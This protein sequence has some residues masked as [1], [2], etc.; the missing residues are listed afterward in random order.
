MNVLDILILIVAILFGLNGFYR[1]LIHQIFFFVSIF[2]GIAGG[3][4]A[5]PYVGELFGFISKSPDV[6]R[7]LGFAV[8]F[9]LIS[10]LVG[11]IGRLIHRGTR[12]V[13]LG[14]ADHF[15]GA[16]FGAGAALMVAAFGVFVLKALLPANS[17]FVRGSALAPYAETVAKKMMGLV[18]GSLVQRFE[19]KLRDIRTGRTTAA[20]ARPAG[21]VVLPPAG[22]AV[23]YPAP[24]APMLPPPAVRTT[25]TV[26]PSQNARGLLVDVRAANRTVRVDMRYASTENFVRQRLYSA[27]RCLLVPGVVQRLGRVQARL[28]K[29]RLGLKLWDCYRPLSVQRQLWAAA[30][31]PGYIGDPSIGSNHNRGAAVDVTLVDSSGRELAMPTD[32]DE[33]SPRAHHGAPASPAARQNREL[34]RQEMTRAG[35]LTL[36]TEWW[37]YDAPDALRYPLLDVA[38]RDVP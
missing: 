17:K 11:L 5:S 7:L 26:A 6:Q 29:R 30:P 31:Q 24:P 8:S 3:M 37:H 2:A 10:I 23:P 14:W 28:R 18:P 27:S 36:G 12:L 20:T 33:F 16:I 9:V 22:I 35:F 25:Y 13:A 32:F 15:F 1:G 38:F 4:Y 34:L 21:P 19:E